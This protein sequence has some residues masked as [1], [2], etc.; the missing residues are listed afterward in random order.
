MSRLEETPTA[1]AKD[2]SMRIDVRRDG[3]VAQVRFERRG[4]LNA[5]GPKDLTS[6]ADALRAAGTE[7]GARIV[8]VR[9]DGGAFSA[10]DD[11]KQTAKLDVEGWREVIEG[12][13]E[14]TRIATQLDVPIVCAID[15]VCVGGAFE[16]ACSCDLR[17]ATTRSRFGCPEVGVGITISNGA[18]VLL[19]ELTG[20]SFAAELMLTGRLIDAAEAER[21]SVVNRVVKPEE[22]DAAVEQLTAEIASRAPLAVQAT[23]RLIAEARMAKLDAAMARETDA[24]T[25]LFLTADFREA[26]AAFEGKRPAQFKGV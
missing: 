16:F 6:L 23:K 4:V 11:L 19:A 10:G 12:F 22:L 5:I 20:I 13:N 2:A 24:G 3:H 15:G 9:G 25:A 8:V 18:S 14:L 21:H 26:L 17:I 7:P 1:A